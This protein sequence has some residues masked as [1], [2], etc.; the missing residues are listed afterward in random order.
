MPRKPAPLT[1]EEIPGDLYPSLAAAQRQALG[2]LAGDLA[3]S[4][5]ALLAVG[6][7]I[8]ENGRIIPKPREE[9]YA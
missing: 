1:L 6:A 8:Q 7:L 4:F 9:S 5:R 2:A 3:E